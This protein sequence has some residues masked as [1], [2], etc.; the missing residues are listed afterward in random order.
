MPPQYIQPLSK[1][2]K[3]D[4]TI[5]AIIQKAM[6]EGQSDD[7]IKSLIKHHND[8]NYPQPTNQKITEPT[9]FW[10]GVNKATQPGGEVE[11]SVLKSLLG[12]AK[13]AVL[14]IPST[15]MGAIQDFPEGVSRLATDPIGTLKGAAEGASYM[16]GQLAEIAKMA[17]SEPE[18]FGRTMGNM[19]GQPLAMELG[20]PHIPGAIRAT[21]NPV[22][23]A[24]RLIKEKQPIT[25][26]LPPF[27]APR[28]ARMIEGG[29]G[30]G[31]EA[32]GEAMK[33]T[34]LPKPPVQM[35]PSTPPTN[36]NVMP[37]SAREITAPGPIRTIDVRPPAP[38]N[39]RPSSGPMVETGP[40]TEMIP[41][42]G[43]MLSEPQSGIGV[44]G[45]FDSIQRRMY[46]L[47]DKG[48]A[49]TLTDAELAEAQALNKV[50][51]N[52]PEFPSPMGQKIQMQDPPILDNYTPSSSPMIDTGP[53]TQMVPGE[54]QVFSQM[55]EPAG[56]INMGPSTPPT[57]T[58][59][60]SPYEFG[61][62]T[63]LANEEMGVN[64]PV[65]KP[66]PAISEP[67]ATGRPI[68]T[69]Q[70]LFDQP[71]VP[72]AQNMSLTELAN[73]LGANVSEPPVATTA[74]T[75]ASTGDPFPDVKIGGKIQIDSA[76]PE[77]LAA[78][79]KMGFDVVGKLAN[80]RVRLQRVKEFLSD[81]SG[82]F[83]VDAL[84]N[85]FNKPESPSS[86]LP[87]RMVPDSGGQPLTIGELPPLD[88]QGMT[89]PKTNS[90]SVFQ[91][92][93]DELE[94]IL[95]GVY[96]QSG[97]LIAPPQSEV[98]PR[99]PGPWDKNFQR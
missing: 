78:F 79:K 63:R 80:G 35:A 95:S 29:V 42:Q 92:T 66:N 25:G 32:V 7:V 51:R 55:D 39:F 50:W 45:S 3:M 27:M 26:F 96:D 13:G 36:P 17:G 93:P 4:D 14:D 99:P 23:A 77:R 37:S 72:N 84:R 68:E 47:T 76:T 10:G 6:D 71:T 75:T 41:G 40:R 59:S 48:T 56:P 46:E 62:Y 44:E 85:F 87:P 73:K 28:T 2:P 67:L 88:V 5:K 52:H 22:A 94:E 12:Y 49:G 89:T 57:Y 61:D 30:S 33:K 82:E 58:P 97:R 9:T 20:I 70:G 34:G 83:N 19:T 91:M 38:D 15:I 18:A 24:G 64:T 98:K 60:S 43:Q 31:I 8:L 1:Q 16:P 21:G 81:T 86:G 69:Q 90:R 54:G 53:R 65:S 11:Q 74:S